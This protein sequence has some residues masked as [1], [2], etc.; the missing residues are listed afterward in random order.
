MFG[1]YNQV[2]ISNKILGATVFLAF[3]T[4]LIYLKCAF[5]CVSYRS[6]TLSVCSSA[7]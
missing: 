7:G 6:G 5:C 4:S 3:Y 1:D 2:L